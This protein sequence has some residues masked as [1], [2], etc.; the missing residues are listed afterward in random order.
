MTALLTSVRDG[1]ADAEAQLVALVYPEL[2]RIAGR[3]L[4]QERMNHTL[5]PTALVH[6]AFV[7]L[8]RGDPIDWQNRT[9]FFVLAA[10]Q[11]RRI[12]VD[13]GRR[14]RALKGPGRLVR[15]TLSEV[16][17]DEGGDVSV[18]AVAR[19]GLDAVDADLLALD[20]ALHRLEALDPR[21]ARVVELRYFGGLGE[22]EAAEALGI[23]TATAKRDWAFA[24][25]WLL[26]QLE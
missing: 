8:F 17:T 24:R 1:E 10:R 19:A 2:R 6:E 18:H 15:V 4:R 20:Q 23:S 5:Q 14:R 25:A 7:R 22:R 11:M 26:K 21:A 16:D 12:L 13:H 3:H 9:H